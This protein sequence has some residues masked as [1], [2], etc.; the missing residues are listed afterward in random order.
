VNPLRDREELWIALDHQPTRIDTSATDIGQERLQPLRDAT[1]RRRRADV[2]HRMPGKR[3]LRRIR[4][5][6]ETG[7]PFRSD[8][9]LEPRGVQSLNVHL[10]QS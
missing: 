6:L 7:H 10:P 8:Q 9:R 5:R 2:Q 4:H 3:R 1:A